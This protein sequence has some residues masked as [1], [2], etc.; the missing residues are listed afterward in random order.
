L[1]LASKERDALVQ[2]KERFLLN[3]KEYQSHLDELHKAEDEIKTAT[4]DIDGERY[5]LRR[6]SRRR[7][8]LALLFLVMAVCGLIVSA[9]DGLKILGYFIIAMGVAIPIIVSFVFVPRLKNYRK[10]NK[11]L[12]R[13][14]N[15]E[16][17]KLNK[18]I[19]QHNAALKELYPQHERFDATYQ[20]EKTL[21]VMNVKD[22]YNCLLEHNKNIIPPEYWQYADIMF[23]YFETEKCEEMDKCIALIKRLT[24]SQYLESSQDKALH[25]LKARFQKLVERSKFFLG[26]EFSIFALKIERS[27]SH[28]N[29]L[30]EN[31]S[32][33]NI[34]TEKLDLISHALYEDTMEMIN[35]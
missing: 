25:N 11:K 28:F 27:S 18:S 14:L 21:R 2:A 4:A 3:D 35:L 9:M 19:K 13:D 7:N 23:Y 15:K 29:G 24:E 1:S 8:L 34:L 6:R 31:Q 22:I 17:I 32:L 20:N 16:I 33:F 30:V 26:Q 5:L 10:P 12:I